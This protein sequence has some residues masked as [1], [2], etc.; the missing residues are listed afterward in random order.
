MNLFAKAETWPLRQTFTISRGSR[1]NARVVV[2]TLEHGGSAGRGESTPYA[3]YGE[4]IESALGELHQASRDLERGGQ[5]E[6][7]V[8]SM[9]AGAARNALDCAWW[10][11]QC[12]NENRRITEK[13]GWPASQPVM[14]AYTLVLG[15]PEEM[16]RN[17]RENAHR[18][19]LKIKAGKDRPVA[20]VE[21]VRRGAPESVLSVDAN[22]A[23]TAQELPALLEALAVPPLKVAFV[24]QPLPAG[25]DEALAGM[26]R[27]V[28][29]FADES[30]HTAADLQACLGK[31]DGVNL[32]LDKTGGLTEA[33][34]ALEVARQEKLKILCGCMLGTS[35]AMA[36]AMVLARYADY[37]DL[38]AP[39]LL[40]ED[41]PAGI[42]YDGSVMQPFSAE[43]WG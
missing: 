8:A 21:A 43:L 41:R 40:A 10:D 38:D 36:P 30:F 35:L 33:L 29:V 42:I 37:V 2:A 7:I 31:Y 19:F 1:E 32:K 6:K 23:W 13:L 20:C 9:K 5:I 15:S 3:R 22:E 12:K 24:E 18:P 34:R 16:E 14:T 11:W 25:G 17:A 4:S 26:R 27:P 39:L 28:P